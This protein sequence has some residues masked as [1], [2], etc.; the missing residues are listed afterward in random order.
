MDLRKTLWLTITMFSYS[1]FLSYSKQIFLTL[2][3]KSIFLN[4]KRH[5]YFV[6]LWISTLKKLN[7][8]FLKTGK[9]LHLVYSFFSKAIPLSCTK[10][11]STIIQ[12]F[13][14]KHQKLKHKSANSKYSFEDFPADIFLQETQICSM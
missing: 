3:W 10:S 11:L 13:I 1:Y 8:N 14:D 2:L 7:R 9:G 12:F 6:I 5:S 4:Y